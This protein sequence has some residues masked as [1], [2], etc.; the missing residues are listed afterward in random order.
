[1]DQHDSSGRSE[2]HPL[3][4]IPSNYG[5]HQKQMMVR[6]NLKN[7]FIII[8]CTKKSD[9]LGSFDKLLMNLLPTI[10]QQEL[11]P[12]SNCGVEVTYI[13]NISFLLLSTIQYLC[14]LQIKKVCKKEKITF[15][16]VRD[17]HSLKT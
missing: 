1:M 11:Y 4:V 14:C 17:I 2:E 7:T 16:W 9:I 3:I 10:T 5:K 13:F 6:T 8:I 12:I 15:A